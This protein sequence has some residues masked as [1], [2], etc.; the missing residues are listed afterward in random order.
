MA[1]PLGDHLPRNGI[2]RLE[3]EVV[4]I[5]VSDKQPNTDDEKVYSYDYSLGERGIFFHDSAVG[6]DADDSESEDCEP[7][8]LQSQPTPTTIS[9]DALDNEVRYF[10]YNRGRW[11]QQNIR[12]L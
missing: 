6:S 9:L 12:L 8:D 4:T 11:G 7:S 5:S 10:S 3:E 2:F 1:I